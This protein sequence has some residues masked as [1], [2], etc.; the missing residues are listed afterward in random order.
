MQAAQLATV[1][2]DL[3]FHQPDRLQGRVRA[4]VLLP[5]Q[6]LAPDTLLALCLLACWLLRQAVMP[7]DL[8]RWAL[9]GRLP[10]LLLGDACTDILVAAGLHRPP[11]EALLPPG[12]LLVDYAYGPRCFAC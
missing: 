4:H 2:R 5:G 3:R 8:V 6:V 1:R 7:A 12:M 10:Y 9:D 11:V